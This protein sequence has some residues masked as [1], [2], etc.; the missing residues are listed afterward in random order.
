MSNSP[1]QVP[2]PSAKAN[3]KA[4]AAAY[5]VQN[6]G[7]SYADAVAAVA[8]VAKAELLEMEI[9]AAEDSTYFSTVVLVPLCDTAKLLLPAP[10]LFNRING[11]DLGAVC[12]YVSVALVCS[13]WDLCVY[14][15][16]TQVLIEGYEAAY[17]VF[18]N[19]TSLGTFLGYY[20]VINE[21]FWNKQ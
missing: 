19:R 5:L 10:K 17:A 7:Y 12:K 21:D 1:P 13:V 18:D 16:P 14:Q 4:N 11:H 6:N 15:V 2:T 9:E 8:A 20:G 3:A